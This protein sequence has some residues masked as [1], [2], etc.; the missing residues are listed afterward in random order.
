MENN[1]DDLYQKPPSVFKMLKSFSS[2]ALKHIANK[3][4][5]VSSEDYAERLDA[6]NSCI[7]LI[8]KNMRCGKCGCLIEHKAKWETA[9]CPDTPER[10]KKQN[11]VQSEEK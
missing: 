3:G 4:R 2:E 8:K 11:I 6:C 10:W 7:Q 5:N 9:T 1:N